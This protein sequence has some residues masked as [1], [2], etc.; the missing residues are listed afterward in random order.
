MVDEHGETSQLLA[1]MSC[2]TINGANTPVP[3]VAHAALYSHDWKRHLRS[4]ENLVEYLRFDLAQQGR[5]VE[6]VA[7]IDRI[8]RYGRLSRLVFTNPVSGRLPLVLVQH[9]TGVE[10]DVLRRVVLSIHPYMAGYGQYQAE[11]ALHL[12]GDA[13]AP[14]R[15]HCLWLRFQSREEAGAETS[16]S[17]LLPV[18][19]QRAS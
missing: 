5:T 3:S 2:H 8:L 16:N 13:E 12:L 19:Q 1:Q 10:D 4:T 9:R 17:D 15:A 6:A 7:L 18:G 14:A 11:W